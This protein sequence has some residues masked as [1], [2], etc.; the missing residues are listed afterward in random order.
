MQQPTKKEETRAMDES[1]KY[2]T[3]VRG[4]LKSESLEENR[5]A[6]DTIF[7]PLKALGTSMSA[8]GH[9][10][11][12]NPQNPKEFLAIDTWTTLKGAQKLFNDPTIAEQFAQLFESMPEITFWGESGWASFYEM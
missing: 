4:W 9:Q 1:E 3:I 5:R 6:H 8:I 11:Y 12:L 2:I 7:E 10:A